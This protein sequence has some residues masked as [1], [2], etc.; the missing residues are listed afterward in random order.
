MYGFRIGFKCN[1]S[2]SSCSPD[3]ET[4]PKYFTRGCTRFRLLCVMRCQP[5]CSDW[6]IWGLADHTYGNSCKQNVPM[7]FV[8]KLALVFCAVPLFTRVYFYAQNTYSLHTHLINYSYSDHMKN[9]N[10]PNCRCC[11]FQT[12]SVVHCMNT[13]ASAQS[14]KILRNFYPQTI[15]A[16]FCG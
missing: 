7:I 12:P 5:W 6:G 3:W 1:L 8:H 16:N 14:P 13:T 2:W 9:P 11:Y 15:F 10:T 4:F